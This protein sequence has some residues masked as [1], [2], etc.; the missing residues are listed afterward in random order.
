MFILIMILHDFVFPS[1]L[2]YIYEFVHI[3]YTFSPQIAVNML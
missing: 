2:G 1:L 3:Y